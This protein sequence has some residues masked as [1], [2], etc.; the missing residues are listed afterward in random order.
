MFASLKC[1]AAQTFFITAFIYNKQLIVMAFSKTTTTSFYI[2][3]SFLCFYS[4]THKI[5]DKSIRLTH[6]CSCD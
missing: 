4:I 5:K 6:I 3:P 1:C 2:K